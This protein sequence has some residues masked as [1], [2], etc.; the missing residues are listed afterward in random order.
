MI[1]KVLIVILIVKINLKSRAYGDN[2]RGKCKTN[3]FTAEFL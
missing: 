1:I 3:S 2:D